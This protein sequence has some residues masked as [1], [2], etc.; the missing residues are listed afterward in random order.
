MLHLIVATDLNYGIGKDNGLLAH[1]PQDLKRFKELTSSNKIIM[2]RKTFESLPR[3]LPNRHHI[4]LTSSP[5]EDT[6]KVS[7]VTDIE[8]LIKEYKYSLEDVYVIGGAQVYSQL[9][10][11]C[12]VLHITEIKCEFYADSFFDWS[13]YDGESIVS[14]WYEYE[15][16]EYRFK[17]IFNNMI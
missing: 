13:M 14:K 16:I 7:Y 10:P 6:E 9:A 3:I 15:G 11:H 17:T 4:V 12:F 5:Q 8:S 2:G 1:I